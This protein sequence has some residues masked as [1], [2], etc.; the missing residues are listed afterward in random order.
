M[1]RVKS[2]GE[3]VKDQFLEVE[4]GGLAQ[5]LRIYSRAHYE[6]K[7]FY[8]SVFSVLMGC[9]NPSN[10]ECPQSALYTIQTSLVQLSFLSSEEPRQ[11]L[12][13]KSLERLNL[14]I[15]TQ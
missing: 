7:H 6:W 15:D 13:T 5:A 14:T 4:V 1:A 9:D 8:A 2:R 10:R 11:T 12:Q 3:R